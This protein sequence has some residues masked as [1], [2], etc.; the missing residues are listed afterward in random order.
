MTKISGEYTMQQD[1]ADELYTVVF[2]LK[3]YINWILNYCKHAHDA[4]AKL[5]KLYKNLTYVRMQPA[6]IV[7][8]YGVKDVWK[9]VRQ[10][11]YIYIYIWKIAIEQTSVGLAH[12]HPNYSLLE[13]VNSWSW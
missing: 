9:D 4:K 6:A 2:S 5:V 12:A 11:I 13:E 10:I 8:I 1:T 7:L 3:H